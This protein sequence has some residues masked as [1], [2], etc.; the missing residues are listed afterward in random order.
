MLG[1]LTRMKPDGHGFGQSSQLEEISDLRELT[2]A[3]EGGPLRID[4]C[5]LL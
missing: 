5:P 2:E 4:L 3:S 1:K